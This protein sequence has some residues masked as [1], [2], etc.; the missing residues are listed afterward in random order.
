MVKVETETLRGFIDLFQSGKLDPISMFEQIY[1]E[2]EEFLVDARRV[3]DNGFQE[4]SFLAGFM[5]AYIGID[6]Q[7]K[8]NELKELI[9]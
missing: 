2:N 1:A 5:L 7:L 8:N 3:C 6:R 9:D 4:E